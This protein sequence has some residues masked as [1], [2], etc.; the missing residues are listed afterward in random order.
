MAWDGEWKCQVQSVRLC[1]WLRRGLMPSKDKGGTRLHNLISTIRHDPKY[2]LPDPG[3]LTCWG[4]TLT[5][6]SWTMTAIT[7][8]QLDNE[9]YSALNSP[10]IV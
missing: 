4:T 5:M 3:T 9:W 2:R 1:L 7:Y 8:I 6:F 10:N